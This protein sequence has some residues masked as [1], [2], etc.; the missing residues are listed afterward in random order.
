MPTECERMIAN[1]SQ[2]VQQTQ[3]QLQIEEQRQQQQQQY[4]QLQGDHLQA[5]AE[6]EA[7]AAQ[8][9]FYDDMEG[10]ELKGGNMSTSQTSPTSAANGHSGSNQANGV[11]KKTVNRMSIPTF[12]SIKITFSP[13]LR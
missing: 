6:E 1:T 13:N 3:Q 7:A 8:L 5:K 11:G 2:N 4:E 12:Q 10:K 9:E